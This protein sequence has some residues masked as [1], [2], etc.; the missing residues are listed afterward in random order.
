MVV[1]FNYYSCRPAFRVSSPEIHYIMDPFSIACGAIGVVGVGGQLFQSSSGLICNYRQ[2]EK[3]IKHAQSQ[4]ET[5]QSTLEDLTLQSSPK[6]LA[7]QA[8]FRDIR[9]S[10]PAELRSDSKR[11]RFRWAAKDRGEVRGFIDQLKETE[12]STTFALQLGLS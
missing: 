5:L 9:G 4:L 12:I 6:C 2:A 8:S 11:A 1:P 3:Q 10:F 7:A